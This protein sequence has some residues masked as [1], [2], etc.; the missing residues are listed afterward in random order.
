MNEQEAVFPELSDATYVT[1]F[2]PTGKV[3]P[4]AMPELRPSEGVPQLSEAVGKL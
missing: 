3:S 2:T 4:E 1:V